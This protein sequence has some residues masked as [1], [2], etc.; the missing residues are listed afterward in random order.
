MTMT[1]QISEALG[2]VDRL[3]TEIDALRPISAEVEARVF[4]KF[5]LEWNYNSNAIEGN[6]LTFG[7]TKA[8]IMEGLT[9]TG[10]PFKDYLDIKGHNEVIDVLVDI[11]RRNEEL[12]ETSIRNLHKILLVEP[13]KVPAITPDGSPTERLIEIGRYK[14]TPNHVLTRTGQVHYF[15]A[16]LETPARMAELM[17]WYREER[18]KKTTHPVMLAA[19]FHHAFVSIHPF[20]DGN[21]R[22]ARILMNL[23]L[24]QSG[25]LP[26]VL[27][28]DRK[29]E[30]FLALEKGDVGEIDDFVIFVAQALIES[31]TIYLRAARGEPIEELADIDKKLLLIAQ[32][33]QTRSGR[34]QDRWTQQK[35]NYI[36]G[37]MVSTLFIAVADRLAQIDH[38]FTGRT[39]QILF[40]CQ[41]KQGLLK[42]KPMQ[43]LIE[44]L[45]RQTSDKRISTVQL[46]FNGTGFNLR[47]SDNLLVSIVGNFTPNAF[48]ITFQCNGVAKYEVFRTDY[49]SFPDDDDGRKV[50]LKTLTQVVSAFEK[51]GR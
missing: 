41:G 47:S 24:M 29:T 22:M 34:D 20:D 12:T 38:L 33:M 7:E 17:R 51:L 43:Q 1:M 46:F 5:R 16:P 49:S 3:R 50:A 26:T 4:Q 25:Y 2:E 31:E 37:G 11:V 19:I 30:Y 44:E 21:G 42:D 15:A 28:L 32:E 14:E 45:A 23:I 36:V 6:S 10:K 27:K 18:D 13:Y 39:Y 48:A 40:S 9:A 35:Q 8:F